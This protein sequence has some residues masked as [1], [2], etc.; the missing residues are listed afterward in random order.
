MILFFLLNHPRM[1]LWTWHPFTESLFRI[2]STSKYSP[3]TRMYYLQHS[4]QQLTAWK[5]ALF[6]ARKTW[7]Y[8]NSFQEAKSCQSVNNSPTVVLPNLHRPVIKSCQRHPFWA[9]WI[10]F[11]YSQSTHSKSILNLPSH[12]QI[13]VPS[14]LLPEDIQ[15]SLMHDK[16]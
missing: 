4:N 8:N 13:S 3:R 14:D 16:I 6:L 11:M 1:L 15:I 2:S 7:L 5:I 10:Q 9:R 12:L